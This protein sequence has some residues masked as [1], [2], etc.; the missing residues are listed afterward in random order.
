MLHEDIKPEN[1][2]VKDGV[3][4]IAD[5]GLAIFS[6]NYK[7]TSKRRG[8][9]YYMAFEKITRKEYTANVKS[10]IYSMGV[11]LFEV[12]TGR[13]PYIDKRGLEIKEFAKELKDAR[14]RHENI[15]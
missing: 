13:H 12:I 14:L 8:T 3:Y 4:K 2:L 15:T 1:V 7:Y 6:E 11:M 5:F 10:D 9:L